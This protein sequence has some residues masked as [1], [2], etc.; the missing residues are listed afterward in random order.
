MRNA[1]FEA[2]DRAA[3]ASLAF[4]AWLTRLV[5]HLDN[6]FRAPFAATYLGWWYADN[7]YP[8]RRWAVREYRSDVADAYVEEFGREPPIGML[9]LHIPL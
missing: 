1:E 8:F 3:C 9:P 4:G 6:D 5:S 2:A 7:W